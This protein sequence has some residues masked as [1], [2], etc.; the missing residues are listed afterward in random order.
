MSAAWPARRV[1]AVAIIVTL[2]AS[3]FVRA[4]RG[5]DIYSIDVEGGQSTLVVTPDR[6]AILIDAGWPGERDAKRI[7]AAA[8]E[9]GVS[10]IDYFVNTHLHADHFGSIPDLIAGLPV[11]TFVDNG[12]LAETG[13]RSVA[14]YNVYAKARA[15]GQHLVPKAGDRLPVK[16][17][18]FLVV[19]A[20]GSPVATPL[21]GAGGANP[22]CKDVQ[23][24]PPDPSEDAR[25]IGV[26]ITYGRFRMIDLG[27]LTW[28]KENELACPANRVGTVDM[29]LSTRHGLNGAGSPALVH[30]LRPRIAVINNAGN[31]GASREHFLTIKSS[32]GLEDVWQLHYSE[33]RA[34]VAGLR[35]TAE[36]GGPEFN[37]SE[38]FIANRDDSTAFPLRVSAQKDGSFT[39]ANPRNGHT[40]SYKPR[41]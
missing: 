3:V 21:P 12:A 15:S 33:Q 28:N 2:A 32:P 22:L 40:K 26:L 5:L 9:A 30:A 14:A 38:P 19:M 13:E 36:P 35:E 4:Q 17:A 18:E 39:V 29:Y 1:G 31:K 37:T 20:G 25:S 23:P 16:G 24:Q 7:Q 27:D 10:Q 11:R 34:P 41:S 8:K 6:E